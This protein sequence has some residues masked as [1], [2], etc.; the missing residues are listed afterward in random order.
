MTIEPIESGGFNG[1]TAKTKATK[2][3]ER[4]LKRWIPDKLALRAGKA[5]REI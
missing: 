5:G 4:P 3:C 1:L 2:V